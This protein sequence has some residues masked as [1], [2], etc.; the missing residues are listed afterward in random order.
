MT[1]RLPSID[2]L[3]L[4]P[5]TTGIVQS[6][7]WLGEGLDDRG[8]IPDRGTDVFRHLVKTGSGAHLSSYS[9]GTGG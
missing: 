2:H 9:I 5:W 8:S 4:I 6:V 3:L 1:S 7:Y